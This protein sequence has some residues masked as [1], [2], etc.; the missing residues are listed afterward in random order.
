VRRV[1]QALSWPARPVARRV[2]RNDAFVSLRRPFLMARRHR[3]FDGR[4]RTSSRLAGLLAANC[5]PTVFVAMP[6]PST[7]PP[8]GAV[9][10]WSDGRA[11]VLL[12][13]ER[14]GRR[15]V[16][17]DRDGRVTSGWRR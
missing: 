3:H 15:Y 8:R 17:E 7:R 10:V 5:A 16:M 1:R 13:T 11:R 9:G 14:A 4:Y 2:A 12:S 6:T